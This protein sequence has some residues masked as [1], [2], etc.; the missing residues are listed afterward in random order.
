MRRPLGVLRL[1]LALLLFRPVGFAIFVLGAAPVLAVTGLPAW[2]ANARWPHHPGPG[3]AVA[4]A[5]V[6]AFLPG[7]AAWTWLARHPDRLWPLGRL[8]AAWTAVSERL[9]GAL[10][11][12]EYRLIGREPPTAE[13]EPGAPR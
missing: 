1:L 6:L 5:A 9:S 4:V 10:L 11:A 3:D 12:L 13:D 2:W 7:L 8:A